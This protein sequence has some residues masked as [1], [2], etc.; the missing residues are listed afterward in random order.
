[1]VLGL[2]YY[3]DPVLRKRADPVKE[4]TEEVQALTKEMCIAMDQWNGVGLAAPQVGKSL[5]IFV[6]RFAS[7]NQSYEKWIEHPVTVCIN[8]KLSNPGLEFLVE[9]EGCLSFAKI[10]GKVTRP[11]AITLEA[12]D[13][14][15]KPFKM[16]LKR[17]ISRIAM[18]ENDH[19]NG[20]LFIDR[21][22]S[23]EKL[24]M[25]KNLVRLK[26]QTKKSLKE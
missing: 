12:L 20:V 3:G 13:I 24:L 10:T 25:K 15:G 6:A 11:D 18:H 2:I 26:K 9:E 17:Y 7:P 22:D 1:M 4:V 5:R 19:L 21:M 8:P 14:E 16:D 23:K